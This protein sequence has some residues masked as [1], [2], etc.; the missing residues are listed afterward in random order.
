M[1]RHHWIWVFGALVLLVF[2][3]LIVHKEWTLAGAETMYFELA[4]LDPRSLMQGDYMTLRYQVANR[5]REEVSEDRQLASPDKT[6]RMVV[7]LDDQ[8]VARYDRIYDGGEVAADERV[9]RWSY[10][11]GIYIGA[12]SYLFQEGKASLYERAM[13]AE[14]KV[15]EDG[16]AS[17][18]ALC[19]AKLECID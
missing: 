10:R 5:V 12:N 19:D 3:G 6:G 2:N 9:V 4:P 14:M 16:A 11:N 15:T 1:K 7:R 13:Y 8:R 18:V 17:L